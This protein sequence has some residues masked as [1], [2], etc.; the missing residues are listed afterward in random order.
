MRLWQQLFI[1]FGVCLTITTAIPVFNTANDYDLSGHTCKLHT[2]RNVACPVL[3]V[4]NVANCPQKLKPACPAGQTFCADGACHP[5]C[6]AI[7]NVCDCGVSSQTLFPCMSGQLVNIPSFNGSEREAMTA[8]AC[9]KDLASNYPLMSAEAKDNMWLR[10]PVAP[11]PFFT[12]T[13]PMFISI[14]AIVGAELLLLAAWHMYKTAAEKSVKMQLNSASKSELKEKEEITHHESEE[15]YFEGYTN[16][17]FGTAVMAYAYIIA[18]GWLITLGIIVADYYGAVNGVPF[19]IFLTTDLSSKI[20][21]VIWHITTLWLVVLYLYSSSIRNYFRIQ[22]LVKNGD[23]I[24]VK[25]KKDPMI[26]LD[27]NSLLLRKLRQGEELFTRY[28]GGDY[29][30]ST[31]KVM[32]TEKKRKYF[33]FQCTRYVYNPENDSF[34]PFV[35]YLAHTNEQL[36]KHSH[37][38]TKEEASYRLELLGPNFIS[39]Y[40]PSFFVAVI[41]EFGAYFYLYQMMCLWVWYYF[42]YYY[43]GLVQ[44]AVIIISAIIKVILRLN[45]AEFKEDCVVL[46]DGNWLTVS[47]TDLVTGDVFQIQA[48]HCVPCDA[49]VLSGEV[50]VDESSLT[51]EAMPVRKFP[52]KNDEGIYDP[53]SSKSSTLFCG[54]TVLQV[55]PSTSD[56]KVKAIVAATGTATDKGNMV[57]KI[58]FP[59]P[60]SFIFDEQLKIVVIILLIWGVIAFGLSLWLMGRGDIVSW[61]YGIFIISQIMSPLLPA[62]LVV[63]QSIAAGRLRSK[64]IYCV[65]LPRIMIAG[66]VQIFC[67]DKTGTL[68]KEGLDYYG[69]STREESVPAIPVNIQMGIA[70]C[71]A[72]T[73][74]NG[75][76]I[77]NPVDIEMF[78][79]TK[80]NL[81]EADNADYLDSLVPSYAP[82][83]K[84]VHVIKRFEF[85]HARASMSVAVLDSS[86][87]HVHVFIKGSFEKIKELSSPASIPH[88]FNTVTASY[89]REGCYVLALAHRDLG[90]VDI[91]TVK[92]WSREQMESNADFA[93]LILFKNKLKEDTT[94]AIA[95]L[96]G[97]DTRTVMI[98]GDNALTGIYIARACGMMPT[99]TRVLLGDVSADSKLVWMDFDSSEYVDVDQT[100]A[101]HPNEIELAVTAKAFDELVRNG[102]I[103]KYLLNIRVFARM[104]PDGKVQCVQLHMER[105]VVGMCGDGGND[106]GA[107]RA[108]HV[109][110]ALSEAE[111]SIVSPFSTSIRSI[112]SCVELLKQ[113]RTALATSFAVFKFLI[114]YGETMAFLE[115]MQYYFTVVVQ[116]WI[117]VVIDSFVTVGLAW[118]LTLAKPAAKLAPERPTARL[119]GPATLTS[120]ISQVFVNLFFFIGAIGMLFR[121]EWFV[122]SEFDGASADAARWWLLADSFEA[123]L[124]AIV[125]LYQF[126][127]AAAVF[128]FGY[129]FRQ[130]WWRNY[131]LAVMYTGMMVFV[132]VLALADP[133]R[134][135]CLFRINCGTP[136]IL[137]EQGYPR[138]SWYIEDYNSAIG[139][140]V[141]PHKFRW[142]LFIYC[143]I[144]CLVNILVEYF[145]VLGPLGRW[146]KNK[147]PSKARRNRI[148]FKL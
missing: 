51:G 147:Y 126:I 121:Q 67:F 93:G 28:F 55:T 42:N 75:Q 38:L 118:A 115:L 62:A 19:G 35:F 85:V 76:F 74:V 105:A 101:S 18:I 73:Q 98:T 64:H 16:N 59:S 52:I 37:G 137:V 36:H 81:I 3:C 132:S 41:Q 110:I 128:N 116:Q 80:W 5:S 100:L 148:K 124:I 87:G 109:G 70:T 71:H 77:G 23:F 119:L 56:G 104:T 123:E 107:L 146:I 32:Y 68:T 9:N 130:S 92:G 142:I 125:C 144:N 139:H 66:K 33:E 90:P 50:I 44:T 88:D 61:F 11:L 6:D 65:D 141:M 103:R 60:V 133:N 30:I 122:C 53:A 127:H 91:N 2:A 26:L 24:Q 10:C 1:F 15:L 45:L 111:A 29:L 136:D 22:S 94:A 47:T 54:T 96:K 95:E 108:A 57:H 89:A 31:S 82:E 25:K 49:I 106:C 143:M 39:V 69:V 72:V 140:N 97:G 120:A 46:R 113:G 14:Y 83:V 129:K 13:E 34:E 114:L 43:M 79:A 135:G 7:A 138:P 27:D 134:M 17:Y 48:D 145:V 117:W 99:G 84:P 131:I 21:C 58:L 8:D 112:Y 63:G 40:V 4:S 12:Y 20:F 86:T 102:S 78:R